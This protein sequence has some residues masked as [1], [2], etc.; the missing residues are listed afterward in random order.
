[1]L[2]A[3]LGIPVLA[4]GFGF[5]KATHSDPV[6]GVGLP[7]VIG[8]CITGVADMV[9]R[10]FLVGAARRRYD[11]ANRRVDDDTR[12]LMRMARL[13]DGTLALQ[14]IGAIVGSWWWHH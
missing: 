2:I 1:M 8:F 14:V 11:A 6:T 5:S 4:V 9:W 12:R 10:G 3:V 13:N 7:I